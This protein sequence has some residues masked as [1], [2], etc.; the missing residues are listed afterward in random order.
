[1]SWLHTH[2][3]MPFSEPD[4]YF[5]LPGRLRAIRRFERLPEKEQRKE[6]ERRLRHLLQHAYDTVPYYRQLFDRSG[7]LPLDAQIDRPLPLPVLTRGDLRQH[8][9][10]LRSRAFS[11]DRLRQATSSGPSSPLRFLRDIGGIRNKVAL[12]IKLDSMCGFNPGDSVMILWG[13]RRDLAMEPNWRWRMYEEVLMRRVTAIGGTVAPQILERFRIRYEREKPK[14]LYGYSSVLTAFASYLAERGR[15]H[16]PRVIVATAEPLG[17]KGRQLIG[18]VFGVTPSVAYGS[19]D[20]G[21]IGAECSE[22][23]GLHFH[24][25]GSYIEFDPIGESAD[26]TVYRLLA[27]DLLN[28]GQPFIRYD[29]GDYVTLAH[30]SCSCG[31]WFPLVSKVVGRV[32][33]G[34]EPAGPDSG[35]MIVIGRR[36][37]KD[38]RELRPLP[39]TY[40]LNKRARRV[41]SHSVTAEKSLSA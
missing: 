34:A 18:S 29:T 21:I 36:P 1:M 2:I 39:S 24:P 31:R 14:V 16:R 15:K 41:A 12:K 33:E 3:V 37:P 20:I 26:G 9:M 32:P 27:T 22:H 8:A 6:Q 5:G 25:W 38:L 10:S 19:R 7:F 23:E 17:D 35:P 40:F 30:Q 11:S 4:R 13:G 28:Y